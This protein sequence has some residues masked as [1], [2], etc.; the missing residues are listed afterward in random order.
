[1]RMTNDVMKILLLTLAGLLMTACAS[2]AREGA[3]QTLQSLRGRTLSEKI[4]SRFTNVEN[5]LEVQRWIVQGSSVNIAETLTTLATPSPFNPDTLELLRRN[6]FRLVT[7]DASLLDT[8]KEGIGPFVLDHSEW[9]G[10]IDSWRSLHHQQVERGGMNVVINGRVRR[11]KTGQLQLLIRSWT[12]Q[13]EDGPY[14]QLE[15]VP[16]L[17]TG[18]QNRPQ[19]IPGKKSRTGQRIDELALKLSLT[20]GLVYVLTYESPQVSWPGDAK[21]KP[22]GVSVQAAHTSRILGPHEAVRSTGPDAPI[23]V[24]LG[25]LLL[26]IPTS[27]PSHDMLVFVPRI[28]PALYPPSGDGLRAVSASPSDH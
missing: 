14:V 12:V 1:M 5:G 27:P 19:L 22:S 24:T 28:A 21:R 26:K 13:M 6:G 17:A 3:G 16:F 25:E 11:F 10:Q 9:H 20:P 2:D 15:L 7:I 4:L 18:P 8:L 23:A